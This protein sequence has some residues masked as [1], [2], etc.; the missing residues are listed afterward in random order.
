MNTTKWIPLEYQLLNPD[1]LYKCGA[2]T[3]T[4]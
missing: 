3:W 1:A 2:L 4:G